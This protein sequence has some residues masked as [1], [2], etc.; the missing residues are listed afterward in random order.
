MRV[1]LLLLCV[2]ALLFCACGDASV[3]ENTE[4]LYEGFATS[5][6]DVQQDE[7][8]LT[9]ATEYTEQTTAKKEPIAIRE[10]PTVEISTD[11]AKPI[12]EKNTYIHGTLT[13]CGQVYQMKIRG[14]GNASWNQFPKKSYRIKLDEGASLFGLAQNK[15]WVLSSNYPNKT[16]IRNCVAHTVAQS[17]DGLEYTSTHIPVNLYVNGEYLGVY[18]FADKIE[19][20]NGRLE[21]GETLL[22]SQGEADIGFLLEIGWDYDSENVYNRDY[23]DAQKVLRIYV[24]EPEIQKA[25]SPEFKYVKKYILDTEKAIISGEGWED[26]IDVDSW[27]DWLII[28][29]LTFNTESSFYRSC[30][31]WKPQGGKLRLGPVWDFDMAFGNHKGDIKGYDGW[32]T[33][34]ATYNYVSENW[35]TFL[36]KDESFAERFKARW[37]EVKDGLLETALFAV[38]TYSSMLIGHAE[39]NFKKWNIMEKQIGLGAV[40]PSEYNTYEKQVQYLRDFI[41]TRWNYIDAR[42]NAEA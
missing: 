1:K 34:E 12:V 33:T 26:Y 17:L 23:F 29:E 5:E 30:Y 37:N 4:P 25:N 13:V 39:Q 11:G 15:D 35:M 7:A 28:N 42:L 3:G 9:V 31:L 19:D 32:C 21:L 38:D 27:I 18:T 2:L 14:R 40:N 22:S 20:G 10:V 6:T 8:E 36:M 41:V 24:K 16:L